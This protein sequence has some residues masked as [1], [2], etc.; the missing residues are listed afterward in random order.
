MLNKETKSRV[1]AIKHKLKMKKKKKKKTL[2][3][4]VTEKGIKDSTSHPDSMIESIENFGV[5]TW[6]LAQKNAI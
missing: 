4:V 6:S 1:R 2:T 5:K 3:K